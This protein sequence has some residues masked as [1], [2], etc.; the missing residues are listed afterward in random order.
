MD[1]IGLSKTL[2]LPQGTEDL[3]REPLLDKHERWLRILILNGFT[4][5]Y[6]GDKIRVSDRWAGDSRNP[7]EGKIGEVTGLECGLEGAFNADYFIYRVKTDGG[8]SFE[9]FYYTIDRIHQPRG[10]QLLEKLL[11]ETNA[12]FEARYRPAPPSQ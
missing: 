9:T 12:Q 1:Q 8:D 6:I 3:D 5:L 2:G 4:P 11:R 10:N 7:H